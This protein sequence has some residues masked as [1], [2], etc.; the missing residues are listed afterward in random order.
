MDFLEIRKKAKERAQA[1]AAA[2][3]EARAKAGPTPMAPAATPIPTAT[4]AATATATPAAT[5]FDDSG[6][7]DTGFPPDLGTVVTDEDLI[8]GALVARLQGLPP[9][10]DAG[11]GAG[12][13]AKDPRFTTWRPG[14]GAAPFIELG[15][16]APVSTEPRPEDFAVIARPAVAGPAP[17]EPRPVPVRDAGV[18]PPPPPADPLDDFFYRPDEPGPALPQLASAPSP[19]EEDAPAVLV[20]EEYVTF[21]LDAEEYAV[22]IERVREVIKAPPVTE[23]PRAPAHILGVITV[24]GEVVAV[25]DPRRR[26]GLPAPAAPVAAKIVIVDAGDGPCGLLVDRITSVVRLRPGS[27]EPCPQGLGGEHAEYLAGI[28]RDGERLFTVLDLGA[29][30]RRATPREAARRSDAGA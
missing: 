21:R 18:A 14:S 26:L 6:P 30:L 17:L 7:D 8:E 5:A 25:V 12:G 16:P 9:A 13:G 27:I 22:A 15:A 4:P 24:R 23:V 19:A 2:E 10:D 3:A 20:R 29:L 1:R 11:G 28:G